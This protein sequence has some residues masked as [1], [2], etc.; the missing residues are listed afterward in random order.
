MTTAW[1][2]ANPGTEMLAGALGSGEDKEPS[3]S[4]PQCQWEPHFL[5]E[6]LPGG[7]S[8]SGSG[9]ELAG[10]VLANLELETVTD[11]IFPQRGMRLMAG[12]TG[13]CL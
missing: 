7:G 3:S 11:R 8:R 2:L 1:K 10:S 9:R 5:L 6:G 13:L 12:L 4:E